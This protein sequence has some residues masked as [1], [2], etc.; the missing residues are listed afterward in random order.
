MKA[1]HRERHW[2]L[3]ARSLRFKQAYLKMPFPHVHIGTSVEDPDTFNDRGYWILQTP[4]ALRWL[5]LEPLLAR[6][7][8]SPYIRRPLPRGASA[9]CQSAGIH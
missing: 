8:I 9:R 2:E 1:E 4:A 3:A 7:D 5:S 6:L